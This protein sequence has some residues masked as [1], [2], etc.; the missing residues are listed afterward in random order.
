M[1]IPFFDAHIVVP[2]SDVK[3]G[4]YRAWQSQWIT[5]ERQWIAVLDCDGIQLPV[6][7]YWSQAAVFLFDE[8]EQGCNG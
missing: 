4:E 2:P 7:L 5:S 8:E 1:F 3:L 6:V